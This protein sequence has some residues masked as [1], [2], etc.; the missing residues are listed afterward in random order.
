M[1]LKRLALLSIV[2]VALMPASGFAQTGSRDQCLRGYDI[3]RND[4]IDVR[5]RQRDMSWDRWLDAQDR[6]RRLD[7]AREARELAQRL[8]NEDR[9][10]QLRD[11]QQRIQERA[12]EQTRL[13]LER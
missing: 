11:N 2:A 12:R 10:S 7:D 8:R 4:G 9:A 3:C 5:A 1:R 13:S 6:A